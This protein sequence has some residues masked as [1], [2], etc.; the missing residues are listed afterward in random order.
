MKTIEFGNHYK[1]DLIYN[2]ISKTYTAKLYSPEEV[3]LTSVC[4]DPEH[5]AAVAEGLLNGY[6]AGWRDCKR[7]MKQ[8]VTEAINIDIQ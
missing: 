3:F 4:C 6:F 7:K 8:S 1:A 5:F 2:T